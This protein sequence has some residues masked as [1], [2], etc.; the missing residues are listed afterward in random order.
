MTL[1]MNQ[2]GLSVT[3]S[4]VNKVTLLPDREYSPPVSDIKSEEFNLLCTPSP[5]QPHSPL[6]PR[7]LGWGGGGQ[8]C[9]PQEFP[10]ILT[11]LTHQ[12][13]PPEL[14]IKNI[15][16]AHNMIAFLRQMYTTKI[17]WCRKLIDINLY[18][19]K[20]INLQSLV[21]GCWVF[22]V[23]FSFSYILHDILGEYAFGTTLFTYR[24]WVV[25]A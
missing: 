24:G 7:K 2:F 16:V 18:L 20:R 8:S 23:P 1:C 22:S 5:A 14:N 19:R 3:H 11:M 10:H 4:F 9:S 6:L 21:L 12:N 13:I 15:T 17:S 25:S